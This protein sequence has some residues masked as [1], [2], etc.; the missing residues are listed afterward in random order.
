MEVVMMEYTISSFIPIIIAA[1]SSTLITRFFFGAEPAFMVAPLHM[2]SV[3]EIPYLLVGGALIGCIAA[4]YIQLIQAFA[5][6]SNWPFWTRMLLAGGL[7]AACAVVLPQVMGVGYDTVNQIMVTQFPIWLLLAIMLGKG[8]TSAASVGLGM[9]VGLI[10]PSLVMGAA[11]GGT[12]G[13][14]L[15]QFQVVDISVGFYVMLGMCA[16]MAAVLQAPL[17]ALMAV[18]EMTANTNLI[19]PAMVTIVAATMVTSQVFRQRSV[20]IATLNTL[21]L[22]YPPNPVTMHLQRVGASAIMDRSFVRLR[23]V[24]PGD[25]ARE[26]LAKQP[27]WILVDDDEGQAKAVLN[28]SDLAAFLDERGADEAEIRLLHMPGQRMDVTS[29]GFQATALQVQEALSASQTEACC[30]TRTTAPM[31][32][33][34][35][36]IVTRSHIENYR[37]L[38]E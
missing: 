8:V 11:I 24:I 35:V 27:N 2:H 22:E 29:I 13:N 12:F 36:G 23:P 38:T 34:V 17:A 32:R 7:T 9:P 31:I 37:N 6:L 4:G 33:P 28:P 26:A 10:G 21:G 25:E 16:M 18:M 5:R 30:I 14:V 20:F 1:V 19:L 3:L 15:V